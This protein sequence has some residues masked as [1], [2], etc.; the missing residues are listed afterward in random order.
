VGWWDG[1]DGRGFIN[2][3]T[4]EAT[5]ARVGLSVC[6]RPRRGLH[7]PSEAMPVMCFLFEGEKAAVSFFVIVME[8]HIHEKEEFG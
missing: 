8:L 6:N 1:W 4:F 7:L 5:V 3:A 2:T